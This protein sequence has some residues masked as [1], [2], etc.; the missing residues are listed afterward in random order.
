MEK[1]ID[2]FNKKVCRNFIQY[3]QEENIS[4]VIFDIANIIDE[5]VK[6]QRI[7]ELIQKMELNKKQNGFFSKDDE[8][9]IRSSGNSFKI[10]DPEIYYL[11]F[12]EL[13]KY[14]LENPQK[15]VGAKIATSIEKTIY[16]YFGCISDENTELREE[17][18][19]FSIDDN[20]EIVIPSI[21]KLKKQNC[22][23]CVEV[24]SVAHNLWLLSGVTSYCITTRDFSILG[25]PRTYGHAFNIVFYDDSFK[26]FDVALN[27]KLRFSFN[28]IEEI[29]NLSPLVIN[30][31]FC[32]ANSQFLKKNKD[33]QI[34]K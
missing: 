33:E 1:I 8:V 6:K 2:G 27:N 23:Q 22:A 20:D 17:L 26:L 11:F 19:M 31:K 10:D 3:G 5:T 15:T 7:D 21:K 24:S 32:Y 18:T 13:K 16:N 34:I 9:I 25:S 29:E 30:N 12:E 4:G 14:T 28:P